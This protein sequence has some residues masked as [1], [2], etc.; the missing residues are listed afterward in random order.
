MRRSVTSA[1]AGKR[2]SSMDK[3]KNN[4]DIEATLHESQI[5]LNE[6]FNPKATLNIVDD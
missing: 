6:Q 4:D 2:T 3:P 5:G 1:L